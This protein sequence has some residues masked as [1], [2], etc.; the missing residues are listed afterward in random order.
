MCFCPGCYNFF[1]NKETIPIDRIVSFVTE[2]NKIFSNSKVTLS[3]GDPLM[4]ADIAELII[5]LKFNNCYLNID[6]TG[7][8]LIMTG[9]D[10]AILE[11]LKYVEYI[12]I[13]I[14]GVNNKTIHSFRHN[15][16]IELC[17]KILNKAKSINR[18]CVNTVVHALNINEVMEIAAIINEDN[19]IFR[20]QLFQYMPIGPRGY[21]MRDLYVI[22]DDTFDEMKCKLLS[23]PLRLSLEL[24]FKSVSDRVNKYILLGSDGYIWLPKMND[25]RTILGHIDDM[26]LMDK[27]KNIDYYEEV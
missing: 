14:D 15:M 10:A 26:Y 7:L 9:N 22:N 24:N 5:K 6:T 3:G 2:Y 17:K 11:A 4:R 1:S 27:I 12:G 18:I 8:P 20:W 25:E 21:A 19:N 23:L 13:P 16:T